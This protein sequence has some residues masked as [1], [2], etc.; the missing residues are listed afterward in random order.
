MCPQ[1]S[2][3]GANQ[4][5]YC[6]YNLN[7]S[8]VFDSRDVVFDETCLSGIQKE[9]ESSPTYV[10]IETENEPIVQEPVDFNRTAEEG[11]ADELPKQRWQQ[12]VSGK[13]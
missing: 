6:L 8:R 13:C 10:E 12:T 11:T 3:Y 7:R 9:K 1:W 4:K 5:G 2:G